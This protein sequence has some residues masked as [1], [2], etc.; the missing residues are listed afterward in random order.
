MRPSLQRPSSQG[1]PL[2]SC[3]NTMGHCCEMVGRGES[4]LR[5][6]NR[7]TIPRPS[8]PVPAAMGPPRNKRTA[9]QLDA[10]IKKRATRDAEKSR[11]GPRN[12]NAAR[13][14]EALNPDEV[15]MFFLEP[16]SRRTQASTTRSRG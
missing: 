13:D 2:S 8:V 5:I 1:L 11:S 12:S 10:S 14:E 3:T 9:E 7:P 6:F 16:E 15:V 4:H